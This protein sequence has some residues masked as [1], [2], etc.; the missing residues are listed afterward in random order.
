[1]RLRLRGIVK[2][3]GATRALAGVDLEARAG[4]VLALIGENGAGKSTLMK[5]ISGAHAPDAGSMELDG[6]PFAPRQPRESSEAGVAMIYQELTLAPHLN[7]EENLV[8]GREPSRYGFIN[9]RTRRDIARRALEMVNHP[10]LPLNVPVRNLSVAEQQIVEIAR[11]C[12]SGAKVLILDEPT[13]SLGRHDVDNLFRIIARLAEQG[14]ALIYI[15]H[16]LE[17]CRTVAKRYLV[18]RDGR[19]VGD[20]D[21]AAID[22]AGIIR[23]MVGREVTELYPRSPRPLGEPLLAVNGITGPRGKPRAVSFSVRRGEIFGV[24]GLIGSGRTETLRSIFGLDRAAAGQVTVSNHPLTFGNPGFSLRNGLGLLSENRKEEGLLLTRDLADNFTLSRLD[25]VASHGFVS[26]PRQL[27]A[28][29]A[30]IQRLD[31]RAKSAAQPVGQL[32][33]G[34]QQKVAFGRL[35]HQN[36]DV[37]L[38]DEPTRGIDVGA[39]AVLYRQ[40]LEIAQQGKAVLMVS[41]YLPELL[42]MC[43]T[44]GVMCRGELVAVRPRDQWDEHSLLTAAL[45]R[46]DDDDESPATD[47]KN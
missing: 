9:R 21:L 47:T 15:S 45:G 2:S 37:L 14:V 11:A 19:S 35:L 20:G 46:D 12:A 30:L 6:Q 10:H 43:D 13:S 1:M 7:A 5:V 39:K 38:L 34:N 29:Q 26:R 25:T 8:L 31:V 16:F 41:S 42:G 17:E 32:S 18:L 36:A 24:A 44:I 3:F 27:A 4:E 40:M 22:N 28:A 33:G 23:L